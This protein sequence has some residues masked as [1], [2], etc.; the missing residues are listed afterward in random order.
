M[1][2]S[3]DLVRFFLSILPQFGIESRFCESLGGENIGMVFSHLRWSQTR[4]RG[5]RNKA[6]MKI[7]QVMREL[8]AMGTAQNRKIY[9]RHGVETEMYG[10]SFAN[11]G[12][13]RKV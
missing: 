8:K 7:T 10:V 1:D 13:L 5:G 6:I 4:N 3:G 12:Q 2:S 9:G 11:L